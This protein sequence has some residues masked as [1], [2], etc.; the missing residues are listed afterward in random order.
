[1]KV[2]P[3]LKR[4]VVNQHYQKY[5]AQDQSVYRYIM[6]QLKDFLSETA[7]APY[8]LKGLKETGIT[9]DR[10]PRISDIDKKLKKLGWQAL[11]V[12]GFIPPSAFMEFQ[13]KSILPIASNLR[14]VDHISYTPAP[15]I[16]HEASGHTP[17]LIHPVFNDF[18]K[19]YAKVV[20]KAITNKKDFE[21][22]SAI[23]YLSDI[24]ENPHALALKFNKPKSGYN[25]S[26]NILEK[27]VN[28]LVCPV[29]Y[30]GL[31]NTAL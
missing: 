20:I 28:P 18:L 7:Y 13:L 24:K 1:M 14:T 26:T 11:P 2:P 22:Y 3:H 10:I 31:L 17:F 16:I 30:G 25:I 23:R 9:I 5:T 12:S 4:Y 27:A 15:D 29:L 21:Q 6:R 19:K 8:Y